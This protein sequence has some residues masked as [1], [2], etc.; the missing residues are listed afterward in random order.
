MPFFRP[1]ALTLT[2]PAITDQTWS[3]RRTFL[4]IAGFNTMAWG[5]AVWALISA[6]T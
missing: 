1:Y 3:M 5:T 4:V 2:G 6:I